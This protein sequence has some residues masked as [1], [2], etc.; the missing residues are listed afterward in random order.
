M[1]KRARIFTDLGFRGVLV[2]S[3]LLLLTMAD[4]LLVFCASEIA[5]K[6]GFAAGVFAIILIIRVV[7]LG[8]SSSSHELKY[9]RF[10]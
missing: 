3:I 1:K 5:H 2:L 7:F 8:A 6:A 9:R 10:D 4:V